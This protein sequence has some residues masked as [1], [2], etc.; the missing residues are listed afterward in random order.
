MVLKYVT[1]CSFIIYQDLTD[2][3]D[4]L[5][6]KKKNLQLEIQQLNEERDHLMSLLEFHKPQCQLPDRQ[7]PPDVKPVISND[8]RLA[9]TIVTST[10]VQQR[11][12]QTFTATT[13]INNLVD[14]HSVNLNNNNHQ[15]MNAN[16]LLEKIK[17]EPLDLYEHD[18]PPRK[19]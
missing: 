9:A 6:N 13:T 5:E 19:K 4:G 3:T 15:V 10:L 8:G 14:H 7:S 2:E 12:A 17:V 16:A 18:E 1:N 11:P